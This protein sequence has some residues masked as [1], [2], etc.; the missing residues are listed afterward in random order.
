MTKDSADLTS[1]QKREQASLK[2]RHPNYYSRTVHAYRDVQSLRARLSTFGPFECPE[3]VPTA[4][5][6][7][8]D[9]LLEHC[10]T[11]FDPAP[12]VIERLP[13]DFRPVALARLGLLKDVA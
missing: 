5:A 12:D 7:L 1:A 3:I 6:I 13:K 10:V 8:E 2:P 9:A 4:L 11:M